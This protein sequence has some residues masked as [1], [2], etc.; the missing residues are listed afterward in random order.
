VEKLLSAGGI[1]VI[2]GAWRVTSLNLVDYKNE[3]FKIFAL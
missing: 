2:K 3:D 1:K